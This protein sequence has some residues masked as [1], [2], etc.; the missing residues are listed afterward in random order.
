MPETFGTAQRPWTVVDGVSTSDDGLFD[1]DEFAY[2]NTRPA[3]TLA[4]DGCAVIGTDTDDLEVANT[5]ALMFYGATTSSGITSGEARAR[6]WAI[7]EAAH[8]SEV[9]AAWMGTLLADVTLRFGSTTIPTSDIF[10]GPPSGIPFRFAC[11]LLITSDRTLTPP[12]LRVVG[13]DSEAGTALLLF[14]S[15]GAASIAVQLT[16]LRSND[17]TTNM[18][19]LGFCYRTL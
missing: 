11:D 5:L 13:Q 4:G 14:D 10:P 8:Q 15:I 6:I 1:A 12:A 17:Q 3:L 16:V 18:Q 19:S 7:S 2:S 9:G